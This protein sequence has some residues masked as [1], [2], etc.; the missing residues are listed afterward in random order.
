M[1]INRLP[2]LL[3]SCRTHRLPTS[4]R[5]SAAASGFCPFARSAAAP[6]CSPLP[7]SPYGSIP[8]SKIFTFP[9]ALFA[10][11]SSRRPSL[12]APLC[13]LALAAP[14]RGAKSPHSRRRILTPCAPGGANIPAPRSQCGKNA[15]PRSHSLP[16]GDAVG[17]HSTMPACTP[18]F[19]RRSPRPHRKKHRAAQSL[20]GAFLSSFS[21]IPIPLLPPVRS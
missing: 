1:K 7:A 14:F 8:G 13:P 4:F 9:P 6:L 17:R 12:F 10:L 19:W 16:L 11:P 5:E 18:T 21:I 2:T 20:L 15:S 3:I